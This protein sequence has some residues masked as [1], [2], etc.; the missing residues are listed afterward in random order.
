MRELVLG[1]LTALGYEA[2]QFGLHSFRAGR[3]TTA[4]NRGLPERLYKRHGRWRSERAKDGYIKDS[5]E[6]CLR[7]SEG[8]GL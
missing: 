6:R 3:A 5:W 7:V 1:K 4:A 8:L 2:K